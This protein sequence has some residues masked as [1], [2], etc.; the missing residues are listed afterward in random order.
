LNY[1]LNIALIIPYSKTKGA[2]TMVAT[3]MPIRP[4]KK[5]KIINPIQNPTT[6]N[7]NSK[8]S[9]MINNPIAENENSNS[10]KV[11]KLHLSF[12]YTKVTIK[13]AS[14]NNK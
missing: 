1:L 7:P 14:I 5:I 13:Q 4:K 11:I 12:Q 9:G 10:H 6:V 8:L 3:P 2:A